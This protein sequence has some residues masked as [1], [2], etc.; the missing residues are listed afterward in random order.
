VP[1]TTA[2][3][4]TEIQRYVD[5][6]K[7]DADSASAVLAWTERNMSSGDTFLQESAAIDLYAHRSS[8][9][10]L[11]QLIKTAKS[12]QL[13]SNVQQTVI[14]ALE[15]SRDSAAVPALKWLAENT[16]QAPDVRRAAVRAIGNLPNSEVLLKEWSLG[17]DRLLAPAAKTVSKDRAKLQ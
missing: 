3:R 2:E 13:N 10:A 11:A 6:K 12:D 14:L 1:A 16:R 7:T 9:Q 8:P 4:S 5:A 15:R 17:T